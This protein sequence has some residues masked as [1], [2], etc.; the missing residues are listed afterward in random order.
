MTLMRTL[1]TG[2]AAAA[3]VALAIPA[4]ADTAPV[5]LP[6]TDHVRAELIQVGAV[7]T[8]RPVSEF[9]GLREGRTYYAL[10]PDSGSK[11]A[12]AGLYANPGRE[13]AAINLQDQ[14]SYMFFR[15]SG[16]PGSTWVPIAAGYGPIATGDEPCPIPQAVRDVWHWPAGKCYPPPSN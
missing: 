6:V 10:I 4:H 5:N 7:L 16:S 8:G 11:W 14:N 12:A 9:G 13:E 1:V 2:A 15:K 3:T